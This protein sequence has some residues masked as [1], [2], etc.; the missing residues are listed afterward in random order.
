MNL[1]I[2]NKFVYFSLDIFFIHYS[3][4]TL[5]LPGAVSPLGR[6]KSRKVSVPT[7]R[8]M[9]RLKTPARSEPKLNDSQR[10]PTRLPEK[11]SDGVRS[12][13]ASAEMSRSRRIVNESDSSEGML[14]CGK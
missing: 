1:K 11:N 10:T 2:K 3:H 6:E 12:R 7:N 4:S 5:S 9:D 13:G 8:K 14:C